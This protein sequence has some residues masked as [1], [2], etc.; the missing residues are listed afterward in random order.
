MPF[1][2]AHGG[3][4]VA[5]RFVLPEGAMPAACELILVSTPD[6]RPASVQLDVFAVRSPLVPAA[7]PARKGIASRY[8]A[9]RGIASDPEVLFADDFQ[10][11]HW[12]PRWTS[13]VRSG[14]IV[15]ASPGAESAG[16]PLSDRSLRATIP[17]GQQL[18]VDLRYPLR[19]HGEEPEE[20]FFRYYL[21]L[22]ADWVR[23]GDGGKLPGLAGTYG[24]AGW[25]GRPWDGAQGWSLRGSYGLPLAPDHGA[26][27]EVML[28]TYAYHANAPSSYGEVFNWTGDELAGLVKVERWYG[29][30]QHLRLN[31]PGRDDGLLEVW[32]DGRPALV[33]KDLRLRDTRSLRIEH[34]WLN[35]FHGGTARAPAD[36]NAFITNVVVAKGYIG[37]LSR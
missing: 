34:V 9:D 17:R 6:A 14:A 1:L 35:V 21:R 22:A 3:T 25:G 30:E 2:T 31:A 5:L 10:R 27:G 11:G 36:M 32:V 4:L 29:I 37:T 28:G 8:P 7:G 12:D 13:G 19:Q 18:G 15:V 20:V 33:R 24:R 23:A 26:A 16:P